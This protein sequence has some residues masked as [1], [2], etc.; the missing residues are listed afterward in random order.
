M[1]KITMLLIVTLIG[2]VWFAYKLVIGQQMSDD[3]N[4]C[5]NAG[6]SY[7]RSLS[8]AEA[9]A[10]AVKCAQQIERQWHK[11]W[12]IADIYAGDPKLR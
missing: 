4:A 3:F 12:P 9:N 5:L 1:R 11:P 2:C 7:S 8:N 6:Y 10:I